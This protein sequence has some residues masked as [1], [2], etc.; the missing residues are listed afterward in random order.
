MPL[1][2]RFQPQYEPG[3]TI[4]FSGIYR[5]THEATRH[6]VPVV[7]VVCMKGD[8]FPKCRQCKPAFT[9]MFRYA[10]LSDIFP[11]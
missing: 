5:I 9:L 2:T 11:R 4:E 1:E 8:V 7:D 6:H 3:N 10:Q